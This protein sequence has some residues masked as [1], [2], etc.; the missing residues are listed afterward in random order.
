[1]VSNYEV[2]GYD[3]EGRKVFHVAVEAPTE[4]VAKLYATAQIGRTPDGADA[5]SNAVKTEARVTADVHT[6]TLQEFAT[7]SDAIRRFRGCAMMISILIFVGGFLCGYGIR[8]IVSRR[9]RAA[10]R[11]RFYKETRE[12]RSTS[13][14]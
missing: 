4:H 1:V 8:E 11:A 14:R 2:T 10:A 3:K 5:A 6:Q 9:R 7:R 13:P 12:S